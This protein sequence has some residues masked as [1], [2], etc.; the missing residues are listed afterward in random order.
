VRFDVLCDR[1]RPFVVCVASGAIRAGD[2]LLADY[3]AAYWAQV[4]LAAAHARARQAHDGAAGDGDSAAEQH[5]ET[6]QISRSSD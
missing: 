4:R 2:E 6:K 1:H 5:H 3:G